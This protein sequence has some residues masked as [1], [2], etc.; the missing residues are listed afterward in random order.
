[1]N[2]ELRRKIGEMEMNLVI[3]EAMRLLEDKCVRCALGDGVDDSICSNCVSLGM[4]EK[5]WEKIA[6]FQRRT[7]YALK[8]AN[9]TYELCKR[10]L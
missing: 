9:G 4:R 2:E 7:G 1:M 6:E 10:I 3:E 8:F 5:A